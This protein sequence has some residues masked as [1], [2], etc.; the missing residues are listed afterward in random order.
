MN[1]RVILFFYVDNIIIL[2]HP[3]YQD[4]FEKL[5]QQLVKLYHLRQIGSVKWFLGIRV[6]RLLASRQLY[7]VQDA[8]INKVCTELASFVLMTSIPLRP[9]H[10]LQ[11]LHP[12]MVSPIP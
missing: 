4:D 8:F 2:H 7:L 11:G 3:D 5:E 1:D 6:E 12:M 9:S 10:L